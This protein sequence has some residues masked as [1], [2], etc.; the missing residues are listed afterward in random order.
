VAA[1]IPED[2]QIRDISVLKY[3]PNLT[4]LNV[5]NCG[6]NRID[7][8]RVMKNL[9]EAMLDNNRIRDIR[10]FWLARTCTG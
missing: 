2:Q 9:G 5:Q 6:I 10:R 8:L 4:K 3:F 7:E 1:G